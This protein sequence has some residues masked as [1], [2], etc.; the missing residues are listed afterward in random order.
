[1]SVLH[2]TTAV[3]ISCLVVIAWDKIRTRLAKGR[4]RRKDVEI[5]LS[6]RIVPYYPCA[7]EGRST[8][9]QTDEDV[10]ANKELLSHKQLYH[11]LHCLENHPDILPECRKI[12]LSLLSATIAKAK[13]HREDTILTL[14]NFS[15]GKLQSSWQQ[16][17]KT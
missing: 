12:L 16:N 13:K 10:I 11:K 4:P 8:V 9:S 3:L 2:T 7:K 5:P 14:E 6:P 1:M 17:I 15:P